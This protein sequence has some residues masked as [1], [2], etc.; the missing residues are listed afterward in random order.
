MFIAQ[1]NNP[2]AKGE[3]WTV[4]ARVKTIGERKAYHTMLINITLHLY[5]IHV[6]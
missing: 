2:Y 1:E 4:H 5:V 6:C 3:G